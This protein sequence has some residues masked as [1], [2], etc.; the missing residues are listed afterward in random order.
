MARQHIS[1]DHP[2]DDGRLYQVLVREVP[3]FAIFLVDKS[4]C[5]AS[6]NEGVEQ[7][8]RYGEDEFIGKP[9]S[10]LFIPEDQSAGAPEAE[11]TRA[12]RDRRSEDERWHVRKDGA[13][14]WCDG[15][16]TSLK[17]Q[18][19][20]LLGFAKI[21]RDST[22]RKQAEDALKENQER[23]E[24]A[25]AASRTGTFRWDMRTDALLWD[26]N[27]HRLFGL[28]SGRTVHYLQDFLAL[29]HPDDRARVAEAC[30]HSRRDLADFDCEYRSILP[31]GGVRWLRD[32]AKT[33][34]G[35]NDR[36]PYMTGACIDV[37]ARKQDEE[38]RLRMLAE[39]AQRTAELDAILASM[40]DA[41]YVGDENGIR[42]C[43]ALAVEMLGFA[44]KEELHEK[45][46]TVAERIQT[47]RAD[48]GEPL[49]VEQ[50]PFTRALRGETV[51]EE[52]SARNLHTGKEVI[53]RC[54]AAPVRR[55][56]SV[57]SA[58]AINTDITEQKQAQKERERLLEAL[59]RSNEELAQFAYV[60]SHDLQAPL[61]A[62]RSFAQLLERRCRGK[63]DTA[64]DDFISSILQGAE[65]MDHLI[66]ALLEYAQ[67]GERRGER[68][69]VR[70]SSVIEA[71]IMN[72]QPVIEET[73]AAIIYDTDMATVEADWFQLLQVFQNLIGN[74]LKYRKPDIAPEVRISASI[75]GD[76]WLF[77]VADN[78]L[79]VP[80]ES[81]KRIFEPLKRLHG[82]EIA[83]A[84]IGL[85][86][87]KKVIENMGGRIWV[88][89]EP[90]QGSTFW[91]TLP[92]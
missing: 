62:V 90:G 5:I 79:G 69:P 2:E 33:F 24:A 38:E 16:L 92:K 65:N 29:V 72:L 51:I 25:L 76:E 7:I 39:R 88:E 75:R 83:G 48:T 23:L 35:E 32:R 1:C 43:N 13:R 67:A 30:E 66:H 8:L 37:T 64:A 78:G 71:V 80:P 84:G 3:D 6:W 44:S 20:E 41:V 10:I 12:A 9:F 55:D 63:L 61:R 58:V 42:E 53:V 50:Q 74:A 45:I 82:R 59:K 31:D 17:T 18:D 36:A 21:M 68:T 85:S 77:G 46:G 47:R 56:G 81:Y 40:P 11:M 15:V 52:V 14:F 22:R 26:D 34:A 91:F 60:V 73:G 28:E 87:C 86:V 27:L 89:S 19:G 4:G 57:V 70:V 54:A 49:S